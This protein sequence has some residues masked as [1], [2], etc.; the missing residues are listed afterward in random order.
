MTSVTFPP[1]LGGDGSTVSDDANTSTGLA[2]GGHRT[3]F[4]PA[5]AQTVAMAQTALNKAAEAAASAASA[6][7]APGTSATSTTS[8]TI[9]TGSKSLTLAQTGKSFVIGQPVII[10]STAVPTNWMAGTITAFNSGTGAMTVGVTLTNGSGTVADWSVALSGPVTPAVLRTGDT[11]TGALNMSGAAINEA[12]GAAVASSATVNLDTATGNFVHITGTTT[13]TAITLAQGAERVVVFDGALTLTNSANLILPRGTNIAV[14]AGDVAVFRG[15]G[16]GVTRCV[17]FEA[18]S[19]EESAFT[20]AGSG[21]AYTV[22]PKFAVGSYVAGYRI[23]VNF[24]AA[25]GASPTLQISGVA[26]PPTLVK[27]N[28]DGT[29]SNIAANNIPANHRADVVLLSATQALVLELPPASRTGILSVAASVAANALTLTLN[30]TSLDFRSTT[31]TNGVPVTRAVAS[32]IS[33]TVPSGATLGTVNA[34]AAR[35]AII[36][37]DNAGTVELA[38]MNLAG[39]GNL[40]ETGLLTTTT[41][42]GTATSAGVAYST[43]GRTN[44]AFR[45]VGFIDITQATAGTWASAPTLVQGIGGQALAA[46]SSMGY[47][48]SYQNLSGSRSLSTNYYNITGK[49]ITVIFTGASSAQTGAAYVNSVQITGSNGRSTYFNGMPLT[50]VVPPGG[51]YQ[52]TGWD[53]VY[54][55]AE[56]R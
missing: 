32:A 17:L 42:S 5:L 4:V 2:N 27:Q 10:A 53:S 23:T 24:H 6:V 37:I 22:T 46:M 41:I 34:T 28:A 26:S 44:V 36:A 19:K 3:R 35:L 40:D 51:V 25:S 15:E 7:N 39:G 20:T 43:T 8:L 13:I 1:A 45:V 21:T 54:F 50:F 29:F 14:A 55:W 12:E 49:P 31:L 56:L 33:L 52:V 16:T 18:T 30:P 11:M 47:G 38:V 9:G 48:Q